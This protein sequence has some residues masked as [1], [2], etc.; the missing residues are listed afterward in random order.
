MK[1]KE[2]NVGTP[3]TLDEAIENALCIGPLS[4]IEERAYQHIKDF[5]AQKFGVAYMT[6]DH[7]KDTLD[8]LAHLFEQVTRREPKGEL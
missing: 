7:D 1:S 6:Y 4:G 2:R 8:A 3:K 5:L